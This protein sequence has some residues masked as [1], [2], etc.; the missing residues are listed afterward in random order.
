MQTTISGM[1]APSEGRR[2]FYSIEITHFGRKKTEIATGIDWHRHRHLKEATIS[3]K[4]T[5][6]RPSS[7]RPRSSLSAAGEKDPV[8]A[9]TVDSVA[10]QI[11]AQIGFLDKRRGR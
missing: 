1:G 11:Q 8:H 5:A 4:T 9:A 2:W 7:A 6:L 3:A 10:E